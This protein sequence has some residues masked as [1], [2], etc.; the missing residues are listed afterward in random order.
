MVASM[1]IILT[2]TGIIAIVGGRVDT[3][4]SVHE[5]AEAKILAENIAETVEMVTPAE[6]DAP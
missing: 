1:I 5:M 3:A 4:N 2:I 6:M